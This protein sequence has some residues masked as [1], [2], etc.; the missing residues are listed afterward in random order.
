MMSFLRSR[1]SL[2]GESGIAMVLVIMISA[3]MMILATALIDQVRAESD[4]AAHA[5]WS[6]AAYQAAEAGLDDYVA[7]LVDDHAYYLHNVHPAESTR[8]PSA[9]ITV[10]ANDCNYDP[11]DATST[12]V[13][14]AYSKTWT[15]PN[16]KDH[17][18]QLPNGLFYNLQVYPPGSAGNSTTSVRIVSTGLSK[19][20]AASST[21]TDMRA[22]ETYVRP[23]NLT[24]F[25]R[26]SDGDVS[27]DA[28]TF[29]KI[30]SN[31]NVTHT[32]TAHADIFAEGAV[33]GSP[34]MVDGAV[35]YAN[36]A[37]PASKLK[38]HPIAFSK[39]LTS[40][41]DIK[42]AAQT[43]GGIYLNQ[44]GATSWKIVF[45]SAGN[46][47]AAPCTGASPE[48]SPGPTCGAALTYQMPTNGAIYSDVT[49][50]VS[51]QVNGRA[52]V[53]VGLGQDI[54]VAGPIA[55]LVAGDD[56][57][58]LVADTDLWVAEYAPAQL[59]WTAAVLVERNTWHGAGASHGPGSKMTF[60]GSSATLNGGSFAGQ[61]ATRV[62]GYDQNLQYLSPP[63][64]PAV[65][66]TYSVT[67]FREV[68]P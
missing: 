6:S 8:S 56:V 25:Y 41:T 46:F 20:R 35:A 32:D 5:S 44:A 59:N 50:I 2:Q 68:T 45:S 62:Y 40:L 11:K 26:F 60:T 24:D 64:F 3:A 38:N 23:S 18:C 43:A 49:V 1:L 17:W 30:Y 61:Y 10:A 42:R 4:R 33:N 22:I 9:G 29:G 39:F 27:I 57:I 36:G 31:R 52:T 7:K 12:Q 51:G 48:L 58:G 67:F 16:G 55:P 15:Y 14:W 28:E 65:D 66:D 54:V 47:T 63:W 21:A 53:G 19:R 13:A 34:N 37:F